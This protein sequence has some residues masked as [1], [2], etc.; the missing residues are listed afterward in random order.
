MASRSNWACSIVGEYSQ[1]AVV[2]SGMYPSL[3]MS[4][5]I[6][7]RPFEHLLGCGGMR[8]IKLC[9]SHRDQIQ[10]LLAPN[11][12]RLTQYA[13]ITSEQL[14]SVDQTNQNSFFIVVPCLPRGALVEIVP[15]FAPV[16]DGG[17]SHLNRILLTAKTSRSLKI[18]LMS[19]FDQH[20]D[21]I[22]QI[23]IYSREMTS[24]KIE[25]Y[26]RTAAITTIFVSNIL[27]NGEEYNFA[28]VIDIFPTEA[29]Q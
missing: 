26:E 8:Q 4:G 25:G 27:A 13:F 2:Y 1:G 15:H 17:Q 11:L 21:H 18:E 23:L 7:L 24:W 28:T 20:K 10:K 5:I 19:I 14:T 6:G 3:F 16:A 12:T 9:T 22:F 29:I